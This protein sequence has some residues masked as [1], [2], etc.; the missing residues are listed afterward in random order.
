M[1]RLRGVAT[2][3]ADGDALTIVALR[4]YTATMVTYNLTIDLETLQGRV[5]MLP[6]A[7]AD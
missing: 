7:S 5:S 3:S 4:T 2:I 6:A 1:Y